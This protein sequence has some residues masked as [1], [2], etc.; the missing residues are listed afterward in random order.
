[1]MASGVTRKAVTLP[2]IDTF[3]RGSRLV[4]PTL[5]TECHRSLA[6]EKDHLE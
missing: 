2:K 6:A 5:P 1:L 3:A 4:T